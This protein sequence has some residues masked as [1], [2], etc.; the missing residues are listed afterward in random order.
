MRLAVVVCN[1]L[2]EHKNKYKYLVASSGCTGVRSFDRHTDSR[3]L[4]SN[5]GDC[6]I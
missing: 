6:N 4:K 2:Q 5:R 3:Y 1:T